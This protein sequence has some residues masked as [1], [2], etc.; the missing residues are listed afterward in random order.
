MAISF[1]GYRCPNCKASLDGLSVGDRCKKC[2]LVPDTHDVFSQRK[3]GEIRISRKWCMRIGALCVF[4]FGLA[5]IGA[6][7]MGVE[8][9]N[10]SVRGVKS[11]A[12]I[13]AG[14][15]AMLIMGEMGE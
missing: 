3:S 13:I 12:Y 14:A 7:F 10:V 5:V 8:D 2:K 9:G 6:R 11:G 1:D 4:L 15:V